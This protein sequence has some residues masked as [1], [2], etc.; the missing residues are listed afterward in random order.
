MAVHC[1]HL[2]MLFS[3]CFLISQTT[4]FLK[5][6][7][8]NL[9]QREEGVRQAGRVRELNHRQQQLGRAVSLTPAWKPRLWSCSQQMVV[10]QRMP[11]QVH[12]HKDPSV[13]SAADGMH[14]VA[15]GEKWK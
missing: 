5:N 4:L 12:T 10:T 8:A 11:R 2:D 1:I 13:G 15:F 14:G 6:F 9:K 7:V 3:L